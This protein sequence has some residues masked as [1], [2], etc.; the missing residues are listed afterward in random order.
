VARLSTAKLASMFFNARMYAVTPAVKAAWREVLGWAAARAGLD[1]TWL[2]HDPPVP[3]SSL[4]AR[5]DL[6]AVMMCGLPFSRRAAPATVVAAPVPSPARYQGYPV[7][8]TDIAV[9]GESTFARLE[10]TLGG[11]IGWTSP[12]SQS[13]FFALRWHLRQRGLDLENW[14][15]AVG[16]LLNPQGVAAAL[17]DGRIDVGPLDSYSFDLLRQEDPSLGQKLRVIA[18]TE[19]TPIPPL[20]ATA[21]LDPATLA[22]VRDALFA[23]AGEPSLA[24]ARKRL[25][26]ERFA[27]AEP[28]DYDVLRERARKMSPE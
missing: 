28:G 27:A 4:W 12:D 13:G 19:A 20:V 24:E 22:R 25:L 18:T 3:M 5:E 6:G 10:D 14:R 23:V 26:L 2:E 15:E 1:W 11:R 9:R 7:Y 8:F 17:L 21:P 16:G